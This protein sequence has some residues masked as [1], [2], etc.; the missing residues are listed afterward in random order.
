M[1][2]GELRPTYNEDSVQLIERDEDGTAIVALIE[3]QPISKNW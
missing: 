1:A 2:E 3:Q